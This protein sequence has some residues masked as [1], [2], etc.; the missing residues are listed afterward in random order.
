MK[1]D[2]ASYTIEHANGS[3]ARAE[4]EDEPGAAAARVVYMLGGI[5]VFIIAL[6]FIL[7]L[8]GASPE[9]P[10]ASFIYL[11]SQPFLAPF[12]L[13]FDYQARYGNSHVE[14]QTIIAVVIYGV[15]AWLIVQFLTIGTK[16][17]I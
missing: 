12:F 9:D 14:T 13:L 3:I 7:G 8:V 10:F 5:I 2:K 11:T 1:S 16:K 4:P 15:A 17:N 6:R